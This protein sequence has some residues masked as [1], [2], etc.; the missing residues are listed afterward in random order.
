MT[1]FAIYLTFDAETEDAL[2]TLRE[3]LVSH[4]QGLPPVAGKMSPHLTLLVFDAGDPSVVIKKFE[5]LST[6][7]IS[8]PIMLDGLDAFL[9]KR[10]VLY[11]KPIPNRRIKEQQQRCFD[12][13]TDLKMAHGYKDPNRWKPHITLTKGISNDLFIQAS[14][15]AKDQ[16]R[17]RKAF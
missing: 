13:F 4:I 3:D 10:N 1:R 17:V 8:L 12:Y 15:F 5:A 6:D 2:Q 16:W 11:V 14:A 7:M 9:G